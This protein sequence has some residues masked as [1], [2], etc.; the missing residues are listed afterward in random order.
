[1]RTA[2]I[3]VSIRSGLEGLEMAKTALDLSQEEMRSYQPVRETDDRYSAER[4]EQAWET[5]RTAAKLLRETF[6]A[7]RVAAFGSLARR[8]SFGHW[9]DIDLAAWDIPA[10]RFYRA[11]AAVTGLS[12]DFELDLVDP[13]GCQPSVR[14]AI[15][16]DGIDL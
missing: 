2:S 11:V 15:E 4:W 13:A 14:S 16:R 1:M 3:W 10:D 7:T 5:A 8:S 9:S 6:G 12:P